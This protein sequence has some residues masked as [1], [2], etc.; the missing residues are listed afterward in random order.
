[1]PRSGARL[2][3]GRIGLLAVILALVVIAASGRTWLT[4]IVDDA[5]L[6]QGVVRADGGQAAPGLVSLALAVVAAVIAAMVT[7][8]RIRRVLLVIGLLAALGAF[9]L[10]GR[11]LLRAEAILGP[12]A[13]GTVGRTGSIPVEAEV[14]AWAVVGVVAAAATTLLLVAALWAAR[15]W[16]EPTRKYERAPAG[17][18]TGGRG[19]QVGTDWD[20]LSRGH[21][22]T[23]VPRSPET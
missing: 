9:A 14:T 13:A 22:P 23:D 5:V 10:A 7:A 8:R 2:T 21:D 18:T 17:M 3:R 20:A 12:L 15:T 4:G 6:G 16:P 11:V 19:E 1:M